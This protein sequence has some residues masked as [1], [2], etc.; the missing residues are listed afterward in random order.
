MFFQS[1]VVSEMWYG[2]VYVGVWFCVNWWN[3]NGLIVE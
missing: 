3:G 2:G 1:E